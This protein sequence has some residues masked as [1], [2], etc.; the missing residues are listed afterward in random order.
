MVG[1]GRKGSPGCRGHGSRLRPRPGRGVRPTGRFGPVQF[2]S[3]GSGLCEPLRGWRRLTLRQ[4]RGSAGG[5]GPPR[6]PAARELPAGQR[7]PR[8]PNYG[9]RRP[10]RPR[11]SRPAPRAQPPPFERSHG[12]R[13]RSGSGATRGMADLLRSH[14]RRHLPQLALHRGLRLHARAGESGEGAGPRGAGPGGA[15]GPSF[16]PC[17]RRWRRRVSC[18]APARTA[19][20]WRSASSASRSWRAGSPTTT[21]CE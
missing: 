20:T 1:Q 2:V 5:S 12:A 4:A 7:R 8:R 15:N 11:R 14:P 10:A 13:R 16:S 6:A 18:T 3:R 17:G 9:S 19:P 21:R